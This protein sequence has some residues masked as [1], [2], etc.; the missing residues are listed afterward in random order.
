MK[1]EVL[2]D[3]SS[4]SGRWRTGWVGRRGRLGSLRVL[5]GGVLGALL[6]EG[7]HSDAAG[8]A[9]D[10]LVRGI[11]GMAVDTQMGSLGALGSQES[12]IEG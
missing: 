9:L 2:R 1:M 11:I 10:V 4:L 5:D 6:A 3:G 12:F 8:G 7:R